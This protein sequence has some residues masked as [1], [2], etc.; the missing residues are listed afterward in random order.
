MSYDVDVI[1]SYVECKEAPSTVRYVIADRLIDNGPICI[2]QNDRWML[3]ALST[4]GL[5]ASRRRQWG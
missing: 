2:R 4:S 3:H 5:K 1:P